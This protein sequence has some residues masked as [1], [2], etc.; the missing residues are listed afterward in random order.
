VQIAGLNDVSAKKGA[1][2]PQAGGARGGR[3]FRGAAAFRPALK[4][5]PSG[6][7]GSTT[8]LSPSSGGL[9]WRAIRLTQS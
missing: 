2:A 3:K 4:P 6:E 8:T 7:P 5:F 1:A 9:R